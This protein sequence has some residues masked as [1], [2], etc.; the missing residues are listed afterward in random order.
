MGAK[1]GNN[2]FTAIHSNPFV[3]PIFLALMFEENIKP[4]RETNNSRFDVSGKYQTPIVH[5]SQRNG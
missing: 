5:E 3:K 2:H 1:R 4:F